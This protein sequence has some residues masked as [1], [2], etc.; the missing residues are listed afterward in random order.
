MTGT[1]TK[2]CADGINYIIYGALAAW[3]T[4][5]L[6]FTTL[7]LLLGSA[8]L[9]VAYFFR[10]PP[11]VV[12]EEEGS[13]TAPAYGKIVVVEKVTEPHFLER[14]MI[15]VSTFLSIFDCHIQRFPIAGK[16]VRTK[17]FEGKFFTANLKRAS[18]EN[19]RH[20]VL[21]ETDAGEEIVVVQI[22]GFLARRIVFDKNIGDKVEKG[23][24]LGM[25]KFGSRV[26]I[27]LP[28][29]YDVNVQID[30]KVKGGETIIGWTKTAPEKA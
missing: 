23:Q 9:F 28:L 25:I 4:A 19:E 1:K 13:I 26:D 14:E 17:Y 15:K 22:A 27:Y 30:E 10:D 12:P 2:I 6:G 20:A 21:I 5:L 7:S 18:Y 3:I 24:R 11:V 8:T 16:L 29:D